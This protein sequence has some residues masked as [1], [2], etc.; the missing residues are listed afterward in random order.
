MYWK[1]VACF[2]VGVTKTHTRTSLCTTVIRTVTWRYT[3]PWY[4]WRKTLVLERHSLMDTGI[5]VQ[6]MLIQQQP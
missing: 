5:L 6:S 1:H 3:M 2:S 4:A